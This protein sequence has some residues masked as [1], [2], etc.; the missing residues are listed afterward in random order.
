MNKELMNKDAMSAY[1]KQLEDENVELKVYAKTNALPEIDSPLQKLGARLVD[2]LDGEQFDNLE[3]YLL[4]AHRE[5]ELLT[6]NTNALLHQIDIGDFIDS[7]GHSAK[8]L[9]PV[10]DLMKLLSHNQR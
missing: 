8:M 10:H 7:N 6:A 3:Q 5:I 9:K 2:L 4:A 1:A